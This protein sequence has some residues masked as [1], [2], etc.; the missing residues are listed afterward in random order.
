MGNSP[1]DP[2]G[3]RSP[4]R[5]GRRRNVADLGNGTCRC[6]AVGH[7]LGQKSVLVHRNN[8]CVLCFTTDVTDL[9]T[10]TSSL[11]PAPRQFPVQETTK[12]HGRRS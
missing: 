2:P 9:L 12:R 8:T 1:Y 6:V 3:W 5:C 11:F 10:H 4:L 7:H